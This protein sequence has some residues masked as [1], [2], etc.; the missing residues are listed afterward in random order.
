VSNVNLM[1]KS[2]MNEGDKVERKEFYMVGNK[3]QRLEMIFNSKTTAV[4]VI[5]ES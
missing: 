1:Q 5:S 3:E 2:K 4:N